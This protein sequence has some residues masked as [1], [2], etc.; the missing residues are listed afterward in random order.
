MSASHGRVMI[1][2]QV[3]PVKFIKGVIRM[4]IGTVTTLSYLQI[5]LVIA[6]E[7]RLFEWTRKFRG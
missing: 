2:V 3:I 4:C 7:T 6:E 5:V 1:K